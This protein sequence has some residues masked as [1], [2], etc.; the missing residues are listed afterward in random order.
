ME[1]RGGIRGHPLVEIEANAL[2]NSHPHKK[3]GIKVKNMT[4]EIKPLDEEFK[5]KVKEEHTRLSSQS[6]LSSEQ[7]TEGAWSNTFTTYFSKVFAATLGSFGLSTSS[8]QD[9][10]NSNKNKIN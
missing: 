4:Y 9:N 5:K 2:Y 6:S 7:S 8:S 1:I 3:H 10:S